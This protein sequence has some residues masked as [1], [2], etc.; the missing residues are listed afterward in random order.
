MHTG[1]IVD[2]AALLALRVDTRP[3]PQ[4]AASRDPIREAH[5]A[6]LLL[7]EH[8]RWSLD[9]LKPLASTMETAVRD[10]TSTAAQARPMSSAPAHT[11]ARD[12][13]RMRAEI[14]TEVLII[15]LL[16]RIYCVLLTARGCTSRNSQLKSLVDELATSMHDMGHFARQ[17]FILRQPDFSWSLKLYRLQKRLDRWSDILLAPTIIPNRLDRFWMD[18]S[19]VEEWSSHPWSQMTDRDVA[20]RLL[21]RAIQ[22]AV[23]AEQAVPAPRDRLIEQL[24][25]SMTLLIP[26]THFTA[27]GRLMTMAQCRAAG[28]SS[29]TRHQWT[30]RRR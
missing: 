11:S 7:S 2:V 24:L 10:L 17:E 14:V 28:V 20:G 23:P 27:D 4:D 16:V 8:W 19:Q 25:S 6:L 29:D 3:S 9:G 21:R 18:R 12:V 5:G 22:S 1:D 26:N 30:A 13:V 15:E